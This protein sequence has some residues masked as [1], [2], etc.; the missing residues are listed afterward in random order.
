[1]LSSIRRKQKRKPKEIKIYEF[2]MSKN[3]LNLQTLEIIN[4]LRKLQIVS[5]VLVLVFVE[6]SIIKLL[7][8]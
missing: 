6:E 4:F 3:N 1:M 2:V 7:E 5:V 8:P